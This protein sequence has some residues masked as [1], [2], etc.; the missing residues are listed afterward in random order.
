LAGQ[1]WFWDALA[2]AFIADMFIGAFFVFAGVFAKSFG[3]EA[4][5][6]AIDDGIRTY[7]IWWAV[8]CFNTSS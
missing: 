4:D 2:H 3:W 8:G 1:T 7:K 6:E 5:L